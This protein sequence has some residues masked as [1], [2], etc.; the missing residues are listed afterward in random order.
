MSLSGFESDYD[1]IGIA[2]VKVLGGDLDSR[3]LVRR[4]SLRS[5][6]SVWISWIAVVPHAFTFENNSSIVLAFTFCQVGRKLDLAPDRCADVS[7]IIG[8]FV[9]L[10]PA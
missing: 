8:A 4:F 3:S 9:V 1:L 10:L 5:S 6:S 7:D 2:R